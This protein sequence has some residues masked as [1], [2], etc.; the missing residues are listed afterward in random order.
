ML[1]NNIV[2]KRCD[3]PMD[4]TANQNALNLFLAN[5]EK[6]AQWEPNK[7]SYH[8]NV[9]ETA[10]TELW[11]ALYSGDLQESLV[12]TK[13][14]VMRLRPGPG[15]SLGT[16]LTDFIGKVFESKLTTYSCNTYKYYVQ[17]LDPTWYLAELRR[18]TA[19][20]PAT[21]VEASRLNFAKKESTIARVINTEASLDM[22]FQLG[23]AGC[24]EEVLFRSFNIRLDKQPAINRVLAKLGS[25]DGSNATTDLKS[26]SDLISVKFVQWLFPPQVFNALNAVRSPMIELPREHGGGKVKLHT[27]STMGNGFTFALQTLI[28]ASI[29]KAVYM[30]K[31]LPTNCHEYP[32]FSVFGDDIITC[33]RA[34]DSLH[35]TLEWCGFVVN[36]NKS[37]NTGCFRESCGEDYF[38]GVNIRSVYVK[39][40]FHET[41][42]YSLFNR[43]TRWGIRHR[44][45]VTALLRRLRECSKRDLRVPFDSSDVA[46]FKVP[47]SLSHSSDCLRPRY[48]YLETCK[49]KR[50]IRVDDERLLVGA[51]GGYVD[52]GGGTVIR[53]LETSSAAK[54]PRTPS[55]FIRSS[56]GVPKMKVRRGMTSSWDFIPHQHLTTADYE[57]ALYGVFA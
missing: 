39:E 42:V 23:F 46:G 4:F 52:G 55:T 37:F 6:C 32:H 54:R 36:R 5:N 40:L 34:Y 43:L 1:R 53:T 12:S 26:A 24:I 56:F 10:R 28:F 8:F 17:S 50:I 2:K 45:D 51:L 9:M 29:V 38:R 22:M 7:D 20:G 47:L 33:S 25:I 14:A 44:I 31:G 57:L 16:K 13:N 11:K 30:H 3:K 15:S 27:F 35:D 21:E 19:F 49:E 48:K 18:E 41:H